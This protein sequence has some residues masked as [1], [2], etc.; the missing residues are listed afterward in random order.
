MNEEIEEKI[1]EEVT[2][3]DLDDEAVDLVI[4]DAREVQR[5]RAKA[6]EWFRC[7]RCFNWCKG[8]DLG[9]PGSV[10]PVCGDSDSYV[11]REPGASW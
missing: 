2:W 10:C 3:D 9:E 8:A 6:R 1:E 11:R 7:D 5:Q 4:R